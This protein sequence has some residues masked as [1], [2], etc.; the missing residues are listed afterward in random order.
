MTSRRRIIVIVFALPLSD[1]P[2]SHEPRHHAPPIRLIGCRQHNLKN[3]NVNFVR[4]SWTSIS[5]VSGSGKSSLAFDTLYAEGQ[6]RY[7]ESFSAYARQFLDRMARP[8]LDDVEG[9]P[10]A[11]AIAQG[12]DVR[13]ARSTVATVTEL[14][15]YLKIVFARLG[16]RHCDKCDRPIRRRAPQDVVDEIIHKYTKNDEPQAMIAFEPPNAASMEIG[17]FKQSM[18]RKGFVR[19]LVG[20]AVERL[21]SLKTNNTS[22]VAVL[23]DRV[24]LSARTRGRA[25]DALEQAF[26]NGAGRAAIQIGD[27]PELLRFDNALRCPYCDLKFSEPTV[28]QFSFN[29]PSGACPACSGFGR[30]LKIDINLLIPD[31]RKSLG[32]GAIKPWT[33]P[34]TAWERREL[35]KWCAERGVPFDIPYEALSDAHKQWIWE[36]EPGGFD[37]K[38]WFGIDGWFAWLETRTYKMHVRVLLSR[39]RSAR[40]CE[41]CGGTRFRPEVLKVRVENLSIA[42]LYKKPLDELRSWFEN[43]KPPVARASAVEVVLGE[44]RARLGYLCEVG[45]GYLTLDRQ[46]R[47][48]SGGEMQRVNL[49]T[50]VGSRLVN[51]LF[52]LDE[53]SVG[54]HPR[55]NDRLIHILRSL[56]SL[57]NTVVVVEHDPAILLASDELIDMGPGAGAAGGL[58]LYQ[59][60]PRKAAANAES[61]TGAWFGGRRSMPRRE[62]RRKGNGAFLTIVGAREHNLQ[63]VTIEVPAGMFTVITGV[64]GSGKSTLVEEILYRKWKRFRGEPCDEPGD[65]D[66][67]DGFEQF[68]DLIFVDTASLGRTSKSIV[69]TAC[70]A[71]DG[72]R[73]ALAD[74]PEAKMQRFSPG[75][76]SFNTTGGRC[77]TCEG[78]GFERVEMQF[79]ADVDLPCSECGGERFRPEVRRVKL[80]G[81][82]IG[83]ILNLTVDEASRF[84]S[85]DGAGIARKFAPVIAVGLGYLRIGQGVS[86]LSGGEAQRLKLATSIADDFERE[87]PGKR[88]DKGSLFLFD[89]PTTGL[90]LEDVATLLR[91]LDHLVDFGHTIIAIEHHLDFI[92]YADHVIDIGPEAGAGGGRVI[93]QG[94]PEDVAANA[95]SITGRYLVGALKKEQPR[96]HGPS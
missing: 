42:D 74:L 95:D 61:V 50:A 80:R 87:H 24:A 59:G 62:V 64:S 72:I 8:L 94:T 89:E 31:P 26:A 13:T 18:Q 45:L 15:D 96:V 20:G 6:R 43:Y 55:D 57:G 10:P 73:K 92:A 32:D 56:V 54:L 22:G 68:E 85:G 29:H 66:R 33:T 88:H 58:I 28:G 67:V 60:P 84:F 27:S 75:T 83:E 63:N 41:A 39:Y 76:F 52:V 86:T 30:T 36:G 5:G 17:D 65:C 23:V 53:P 49:T 71:Y 51:A 69:A 82:T 1:A 4:G 25:I 81:K 2:Q 9:I 40:V 11:I 77:E 48:L 14:G 70:G 19:V 12:N 3:I 34:A 47:T 90:H 91:T 7:V 16:T 44:I 35:K 21:E 37:K 78:A 93:A 38:V 46:S 79:L